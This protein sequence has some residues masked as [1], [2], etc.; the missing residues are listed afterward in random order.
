MTCA[1]RVR[2]RCR[3]IAPLATAARVICA[4]H[5]PEVIARADHVLALEQ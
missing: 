4:T 5:D 1:G 2:G 3:L